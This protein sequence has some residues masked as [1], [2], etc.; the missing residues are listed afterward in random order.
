M[1]IKVMYMGNDEPNRLTGW[2]CT[3][4]DHPLIIHKER[5]PPRRD[6]H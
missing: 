6:G 2:L 4:F 1:R 3:G 5:C